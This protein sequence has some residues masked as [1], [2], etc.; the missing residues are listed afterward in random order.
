MILALLLF[1]ASAFA[2]EPTNTAGPLDCSTGI[3]TQRLTKETVPAGTI[4]FHWTTL[5][6]LFNKTDDGENV[7]TYSQAWKQAFGPT[8]STVGET[9]CIYPRGG[10]HGAEFDLVVDG[11]LLPG[12]WRLGMSI[13]IWKM[14]GSTG[15][16]TASNALYIAGGVPYR[17]EVRVDSGVNVDMHCNIACLRVRSGEK[18]GLSDDGLVAFRFNP[19]TH[20]VELLYGEQVLW[21]VPVPYP[22]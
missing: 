4:P 17:E 13:V 5:T 8:W 6:Q 18:V 10:C 1:A 12:D 7:A 2:S 14:P 20:M 16:P 19:V 21:S 15:V 11:P 22:K 9:R 3:C